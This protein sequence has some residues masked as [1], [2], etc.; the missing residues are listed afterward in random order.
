M[1]KCEKS[2]RMKLIYNCKF[3]KLVKTPF[4]FYVMLSLRLNSE[5]YW[6][7]CD[8]RIFFDCAFGF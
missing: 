6:F 2:T 5:K 3:T 7:I 1:Q 8:L 4:R